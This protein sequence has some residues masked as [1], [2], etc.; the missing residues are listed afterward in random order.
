MNTKRIELHA[1]TEEEVF[2]YF[3]TRARQ[4]L[5][6]GY[7]W[8]KTLEQVPGSFETSFIFDETG[9]EFRSLYILEAYRGKG[10]YKGIASHLKEKII[11]VAE[12][13]IEDYLKT[14]D[15]NYQIGAAF[16]TTKEYQTIER[17]YGDQKAERSQCF[18]MNHIDEGL[19]ILNHIK[20]TDMAKKAYCIHPIIQ[21][22]EDYKKNIE[23]LRSEIDEDV[24]EVALEY[25]RVA[26]NYL[27][28]RSINSYEEIELSLNMDVN[29]MLRADKIQNYKDFL[30]YHQDTHPRSKELKQ[31]FDN[32]LRRLRVSGQEFANHVFILSS[33]DI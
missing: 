2:Q 19:A 13:N 12:E 22:P 26:N 9:E 6:D 10:F 28:Q 23:W 14:N 33:I 5:M 24:I 16:T 15:I 4:L 3:Q 27:S 20:A 25:A 17:Y 7:F 18:L 1:S 11:I 31:Y 8:N 21:N 30:R 32:W 29:D